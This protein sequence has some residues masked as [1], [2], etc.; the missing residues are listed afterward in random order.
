[1]K[2]TIFFSLMVAFVFSFSFSI[3]LAAKNKCVTI[4]GGEI[5]TTDGIIVE[6][7]YDKWGYNYQGYMFNGKYCDA[8]RDAAWCQP[9]KNDNL[10]M[11]WNDAWLSNKDCN[12]DELLDRYYG[13]S[14][15]IGSGA[16]APNS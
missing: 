6:T 14:S 4:Q 7:G 3:A 9:Y 10:M 15:Y 1:M 12:G 2:K 5:L 11:K 16:L 13:F 8:Y